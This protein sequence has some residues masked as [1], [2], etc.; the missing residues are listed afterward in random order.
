MTRH[1]CALPLIGLFVLGLAVTSVRAAEG[2]GQ[3]AKAEKDKQAEKNKDIIAK[4][5]PTYPLK[6]CVVTGEDLG[7]APLDY[8]CKDRLVR[9]CCKGC[10]KKLEKDPAKYFALLD[11][12]AKKAA[13]P[14]KKEDEK[15]AEPKAKADLPHAGGCCD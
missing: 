14:A 8:V 9:L 15:K 12:A 3:D 4:Q 7:K 6:T 5:L 13:D 11:D 2:D 10:I 1:V